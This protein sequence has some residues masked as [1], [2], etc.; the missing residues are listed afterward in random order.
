MANID[1]GDWEVRAWE[2]ILVEVPPDWDIAAI[3]GERKKGYLRI[4]D[5]ESMPR[6][7]IK[8]QESKGFV[9]IEEVIDKYLTDLQKKRS[10]KESEIDV[11]RDASVVSRR[12]ME[13]KGKRDLNCFAWSSDISGYGA[14]WYCQDC[15]RIVVIQV[16]AKPEENGKALAAGVIGKVWDHPRDGWVTWSTYGLQMQTPERFQLNE[17]RLMAGLIELKFEDK[18]EEIVAARWGMA[19]VALAGR[20]LENWAA[21]EIRTRHK[22]VRLDYEPTEFRGHPAVTVSGHWSNPLKHIQSFMMH[23]MNKPYPETVWGVA[24]YSE[25]ENRL[26][27]VGTMLDEANVELA[28]EV[29]ERVF[30]PE[31][32]AESEDEGGEPIR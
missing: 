18:G 28:E 3:S 8:W 32:D 2:G 31:G 15:E 4:D 10:D 26:Y 12:E 5:Q 13:K 1:T 20:A 11:D 22:G 27:Y 29:A 14:A 24:W 25:E 23:V 30:C 7:E 19:N 21:R 9:N 6:V 17:Q 16:M